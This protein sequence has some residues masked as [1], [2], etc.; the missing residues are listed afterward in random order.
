MRLA[1]PPTS[2]K[3]PTP[4]D[5]ARA[6]VNA[7]GD[8]SRA[9]WLEPSHG[10]GVFLRAISELGVPKSRIIAVDLD[11]TCSPSD[12]FAQTFRGLD[13]LRWAEKTNLRF[14]RI[15]GNPPFLSIKS[16][17][18]SLRQKAENVL[19]INE[20]PIGRGANVWYAFVLASLR[21]LKKGGSLA[22]VL[23]SASEFA[24]YS[25]AIRDAIGETFGSVELFRCARPLFEDVQEG[26]VVAVARG[27]QKPPC[28]VRK[29]RFKTK[30]SLL[31][32]LSTSGKLNGHKCRAR[33]PQALGSTTTL[34]SIAKIRLGGVTGDAGYFLMNERRRQ[35]LALPEEAL[36]PIVS[37]AKHL[38]SH[39]IDRQVWADLKAAGER[40]WL[41]S[42]SPELAKAGKT[43]EYVALTPEA[44]GCNK[45]A[46]KVSIRAPWY[47][48]PLPSPADAFLS[49]MS[50]GGP[51]LCINEM[52]KLNAT[53]TL[54]VVSFETRTRELWYM[55]ALAM[56][57]SI[58]QKQIRRIGRR[59]ADGL[60]KYE[61]G[62]LGEVRLPRLRV[63]EDYRSLYAR[64]IRAFTTGDART[65][66]ELADSL[67]L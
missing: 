33:T 28:L 63:D 21:V 46:Y 65:A 1:K 51:W 12:R 20:Q 17:P 60:V 41:F 9:M 52:R 55:W 4:R 11:R 66:R 15:V 25:V 50:Q 32:G 22:F 3:V 42:P 59:Y 24:N 40:I 35:E 64:A 56:F 14:D 38:R 44:G 58:A 31:V 62:Q 27:Y 49:G 34:G 18:I 36:T 53:N 61:P 54:Y 39:S 7:L 5:L 48:T 29:R 2:C 37:K 19:D 10:S 43:K 30:E 13:F 57:S 23:P 67:Q 16:L 45:E 47:C 6:I 26:T 8:D